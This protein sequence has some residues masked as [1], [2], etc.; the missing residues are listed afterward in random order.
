M[1]KNNRIMYTKKSSIARSSKN[2]A[3][4]EADFLPN[5]PFRAYKKFFKNK[6]HKLQTSLLKS[7]QTNTTQK[8]LEIEYNFT[9]EEFKQKQIFNKKTRKARIQRSNSSTFRSSSHSNSHSSSNISSSVFSPYNSPHSRKCR[10][11]TC[12]S[13]NSCHHNQKHIR[14]LRKNQCNF[15]AGVAGINQMPHKLLARPQIAFV[16]RS[17]AGKS[18][19]INCLIGRRNLAQVSKTPGR[20]QQINFFDISGKILLI[21]LPGYGYAAVSKNKKCNWDRLISYY[22]KNASQL[23]RVFLLIDARVGLKD[24]DLSLMNFLDELAIVYQIILTKIDKTSQ[25]EEMKQQIQL[26]IINHSAAYNEIISTSAIKKIGIS[27]FNRRI[28]ECF[29]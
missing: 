3:N 21:D 25:V 7:K 15:I 23:K 24:S 26:E 5:V 17:N 11:S 10:L 14:I 28:V 22:F 8:N 2:S 19:I 16:G 1:K 4:R 18:S 6:N 13:N 27:Q 29:I 20:T 9:I 12:F